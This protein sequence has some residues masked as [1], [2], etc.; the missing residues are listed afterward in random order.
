[1]RE[2]KI[3]GMSCAACSTRVEKAVSAVQGVESCSVNLLTGSMQVE[4]GDAQAIADAVTAAG[5]GISEGADQPRKEKGQDFAVLKGRLIASLIVLAGLMYISMGHVMWGWRLPAFL[6]NDHVALGLAQMLL[7]A[8]IMVINQRFFISGIKGILHRAPNMDTLV[9]LGAGA[10]FLYSTVILFL[11]SGAVSRGD[12]MSAHRYLHD[13]YFESAG[14]ILALITLGKLLEAYS[15][16]KTTDALKGLAKLAPKSANVI[17]NGR[18]IT[19]DIE[20]VQIGDIFTV[21]PG[22]SIPTD[23][24]VL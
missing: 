10:A 9:S 7:T 13:L 14:M 18:E 19:L 4:G 23:G 16:G 11:M 5:Y 24:V 6:E 2:Y 3:S 22:E 20:K 1:M 15:K 21:R 17:R 12:S 8:I